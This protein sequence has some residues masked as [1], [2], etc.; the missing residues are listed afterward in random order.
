LNAQEKIACE[1]S[2]TTSPEHELNNIQKCLA[3]GYD[4][5]A[6]LSNEKK[7]LDKICTLAE[8]ELDKVFLKK[9]FFFQPE[10]FI[11]FLDQRKQS[12]KRKE[13][14][15]RGYTV[16]VQYRELNTEE[17]KQKREAAAGLLIESM[18]RIKKQQI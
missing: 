3:H 5:I 12:N 9:I 8:S 1:I 4:V 15:V 17:E 11:E 10:E 16:N 13:K 14:T 7:H 6:V 2:I 18:Q